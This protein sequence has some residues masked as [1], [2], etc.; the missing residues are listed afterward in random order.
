M[1]FVKEHQDQPFA[2]LLHFRE[3]HAPYGPV[4]PEDSAPFKDLDPTMPKFPGLD[5]AH[6]KQ[7]TREYYASIHSVDRNLG[8]LLDQLDTLKLTGK[9]IVL[10]TSD[11]G[12]MIGHHGLWHKGNGG[13]ITS[14]QKGQRPNMFD[15]SMRVPLFV[16]WPGVVKPGTVIAEVVSNLDTFATVLGMLDVPVPKGTKQHGLD[17][18]PLLKGQKVAWRDT[19]FGQY[20]LHNHGLAYM[21]MIRTN[22]WKLVRRYRAEK[23]DE[24]YHLADDPGETRNLYENAKARPI[25]DQL[26]AR[27][28]DWMKSIDDPLTR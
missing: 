28:T 6:V 16:R 13:W 7:L 4:P 15:D 17:L 20:D 2:L 10:F 22:D 25:R 23:L 9:T 11:H 8:R 21:R 26:Q 1:R 19:L 12:Y 14:S 5:V 24:L 3:P 18:T 27:L